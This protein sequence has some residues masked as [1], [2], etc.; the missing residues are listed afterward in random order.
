MLLCGP[1]LN[2]TVPEMLH[3]NMYQH[4]D[5]LGGSGLHIEILS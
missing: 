2:I 4:K 1:Y 3:H 5:F